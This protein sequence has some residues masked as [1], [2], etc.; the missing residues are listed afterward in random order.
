MSGCLLKEGE[1]YQVNDAPPNG[2]YVNLYTSTT[3]KIQLLH[4]QVCH[5]NVT[6]TMD[7]LQANVEFNRDVMGWAFNYVWDMSLRQGEAGDFAEALANAS[8]TDGGAQ[9]CLNLTIR[10]YGPWPQSNWDYN[11]SWRPL[12]DAN[13][14]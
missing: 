9:R 10:A 12:S 8:G 3:D 2:V 6:C 4:A 11:W 7:W 1:E 14:R 5:G 13:C